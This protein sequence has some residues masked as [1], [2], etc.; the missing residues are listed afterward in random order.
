MSIEQKNPAIR[1]VFD[2][3]AT[4]IEMQKDRLARDTAK[5]L[6]IGSSNAFLRVMKDILDQNIDFNNP[7]WQTDSNETYA[8]K[9]ILD[10]I[11]T[12]LDDIMLYGS[13]FY[14]DRKMPQ[15]IYAAALMYQYDIPFNKM[16][17]KSTKQKLKSAFG[18]LNNYCTDYDTASP[19]EK[20]LCLHVLK[21][22]IENCK[23]RCL[24]EEDPNEDDLIK[25]FLYGIAPAVRH[26]PDNTEYEK[27]VKDCADELQQILK[28]EAP[29]NLEIFPA[30]TAS[31][32]EGKETKG[33][34]YYLSP[35]DP[36]HNHIYFD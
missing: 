30:T 11:G 14:E 29:D 5:A 33:K 18:I 10:E 27:H 15:T 20:I 21:S 26:L 3:T 34:I 19:S 35:P 32:G 1:L 8:Y 23:Q 13:E 28:L 7:K 24:Y 12:L 4:L 2:G 25:A 31:S 17:H 9:D 6:N 36:E 22:D 16:P